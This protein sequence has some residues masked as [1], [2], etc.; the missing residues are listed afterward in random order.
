[1]KQALLPG[2]HCLLN[3]SAPVRQLRE[4]HGTE[5]DMLPFRLLLDWADRVGLTVPDTLGAREK[6][7]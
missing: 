3:I 5:R 7:A 6:L 2:G 1:M 4:G